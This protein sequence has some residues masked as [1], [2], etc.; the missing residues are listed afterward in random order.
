MSESRT[1]FAYLR[2]STRKQDEEHQRKSVADYAKVHNIII[3]EQGWFVDHAVSGRK[4]PPMER[5][6]FSEMMDMLRARKLATN[7]IV[8]EVS[9]LGRTFWETLEVVRLLEE[10]Y[11]IISTSRQESF[12]T[13]ASD[14]SLRQIF[15]SFLTWIAQR[16]WENTHERIM[17]GLE[18]ASEEDRHSG[19]V[20]LGFK[21]HLCREHGARNRSEF[22]ELHGKLMLDTK[23]ETVKNMLLENPAVRP[24]IVQRTLGI[25]DY[26][27]AYKLLRSVKKF[28]EV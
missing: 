5:P 21:Q 18:L 12:F 1:A 25:E 17:S 6:G 20:P 8:F 4:V 11:P 28:S 14:P 10:N 26:N 23:G 13:D 27:T 7:V 2:V 24:L 9:R 16:E 15:I 19:N 22:C 3:P